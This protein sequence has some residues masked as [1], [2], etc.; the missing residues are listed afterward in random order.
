MRAGFAGVGAMGAAM[1][2]RALEDGLQ[3]EV[4]DISPAATAALAEKGA[5]VAESPRALAEHCD[6]VAVVVLNDEQVRQVVCG[7]DGLL[8]AQRDALDIMIHSTIHIPTLT[9]VEAEVRKRGFS[10]IDAGVSGHTT[11]AARGQLAVMAGGELETI[12]R[13]RAVLDTYGGLVMHMGPLGAGMKAK[14]ARNL[15]SF[16][17]CAAIYEG[18]RVAEEAGVDLEAY[19]RIVRHSEAQSN[20]LDG[21]LGNASVREGNESSEWGRQ[22]LAMANVVVETAHKDLSAALDLG[23]SL[24]LELPVAEAARSEVPATWGAEAGPKR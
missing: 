18:M 12:D 13:C 9:E 24:G 19:A 22:R 4:F 23:A 10:L 3:V 1:A 7:E 11:G 14:I 8:T 16:A 6:V 15:L 5:S 21:F 17:Q 20:L 2:G